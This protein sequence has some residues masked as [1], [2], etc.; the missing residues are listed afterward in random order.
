MLLELLPTKAT[1]NSHAEHLQQ[2]QRNKHVG[3]N[4][5]LS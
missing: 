3:M 2:Q 4:A 1:L 5:A